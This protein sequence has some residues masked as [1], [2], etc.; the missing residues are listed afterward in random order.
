MMLMMIRTTDRIPRP[1]TTALAA[2]GRPTSVCEALISASP[3]A[4]ATVMNRTMSMKPY[5]PHAFRDPSAVKPDSAA[6]PSGR[7]T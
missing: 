4:A 1:A 3:I 6:A 5:E 2:T 7:T